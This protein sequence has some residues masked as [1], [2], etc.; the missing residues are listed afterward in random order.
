MDIPR[1]ARWNYLPDAGTVGEIEAVPGGADLARQLLAECSA[2]ATASGHAPTAESTGRIQ[3]A[4]TARGSAARSSMYRD[5]AAG[6]PIEADH[7]IGDLLARARNLRVP[8][9]LLAAAFFHLEVYQNRLR[10]G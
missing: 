7:I 2:V 4:V 6:K 1:D 5:L 9:P 8:T 10:G 3:A